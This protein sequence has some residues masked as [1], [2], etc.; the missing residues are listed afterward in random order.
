MIC[1]QELPRSSQEWATQLVKDGMSY[2]R[3]LSQGQAPTGGPQKSSPPPAST[4]NL[5]PPKSSPSPWCD[6]CLCLKL[7]LSKHAWYLKCSHISE[8]H[9]TLPCCIRLLS[10]S[11]SHG[12]ASF[13]NQFISLDRPQHHCHCVRRLTWAKLMSDHLSIAGTRCST[14][15]K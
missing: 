4:S 15:E 5:P 13:D 6:A 12:H 9:A 3:I 2:R 1:A 7:S 11:Y 14:I 10:T 8:R